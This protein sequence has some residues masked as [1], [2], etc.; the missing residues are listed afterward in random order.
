[1]VA[2]ADLSESR[3][4][5]YDVNLPVERRIQALMSKMTTEEKIGQLST[6]SGGI[7]HLN[8]PDFNWWSGQL[9]SNTAGE[10]LEHCCITTNESKIWA[11]QTD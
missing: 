9:L 3:L 11:V 8:I 10:L 4:P 7:E 6:N 1:M 5:W 2:S